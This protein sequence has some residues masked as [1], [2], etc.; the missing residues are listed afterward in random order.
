M[1][2]TGDGDVEAPLPALIQQR[3]KPVWKIT[4]GVLSVADRE[5]DRVALV[6]LDA[7]EVFHKEPLF[8]VLA[9]EV[10]DLCFEIGVFAKTLKPTLLDPVRVL[11]T[12][13]DNAKRL[14]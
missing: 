9:K 8:L 5:D 4:A 14:F 10:A 6:A 12:H 2:R 1:L 3:A 13:R 11:D 7:L